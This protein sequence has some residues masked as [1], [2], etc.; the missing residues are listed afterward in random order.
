MSF[1]PLPVLSPLASDH[2]HNVVIL[3]GEEAAKAAGVAPKWGFVQREVK[4]QCHKLRGET[5]GTSRSCEYRTT[6]LLS[7]FF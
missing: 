4:D 5:E 6:S 3:V 2:S 7:I 1:P